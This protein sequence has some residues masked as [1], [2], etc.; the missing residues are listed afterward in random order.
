[1]NVI[2]CSVKWNNCNN[3]ITYMDDIQVLISHILPPFSFLLQVFFTYRMLYYIAILKNIF[4]VITT[5]NLS[6]IAIISQ[7][8]YSY[9]YFLYKLYCFCTSILFN[10][11]YSIFNLLQGDSVFSKWQLYN[12]FKLWISRQNPVCELSFIDR[13]NW[14]WCYI[15]IF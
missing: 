3:S 8:K 13:K 9:R 5:N 11:I 12:L 15:F 10:W 7:E 6:I 14:V 1:M 4:R 2:I